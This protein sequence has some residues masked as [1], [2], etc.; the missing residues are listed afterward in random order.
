MHFESV[1]LTFM[2]D[3]ELI[4]HPKPVCSNLVLTVSESEQVPVIYIPLQR[5]IQGNVEH[6]SVKIVPYFIED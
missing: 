4:F 2:L 3:G 1:N 6:S 5:S